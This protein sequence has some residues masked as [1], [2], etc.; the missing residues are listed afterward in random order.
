MKKKYITPLLCVADME[1][2]GSVLQSLSA[3][4]SVTTSQSDGGFVR[5]SAW[6][7]EKNFWSVD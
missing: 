2:A 5:E 1:L 3:D 4:T 7:E 6:D